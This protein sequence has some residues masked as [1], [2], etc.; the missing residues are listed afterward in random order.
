V[1]ASVETSEILIKKNV[2]LNALQ[3]CIP[4]MTKRANYVIR[5]ALRDVLVGGLTQEGEGATN[6]TNLPY[7][8]RTTTHFFASQMVQISAVWDFI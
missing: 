1:L 6:A 7:I 5:I 2:W 8:W 4:M 3:T